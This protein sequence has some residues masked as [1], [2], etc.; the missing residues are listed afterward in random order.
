M[1]CSLAKSAVFRVC[2]ITRI[3]DYAQRRYLYGR[4]RPRL[5]L[6]KAR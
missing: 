6:P 5:W 2:V 3:V 1:G 4:I